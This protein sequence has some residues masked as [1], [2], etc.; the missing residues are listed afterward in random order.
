LGYPQG[1]YTIRPLLLVGDETHTGGY[2]EV[3]LTS[4]DDL[5]QDLAVDMADFILAIKILVSENIDTATP[6]STDTD[7]KIGMDN[8][9]R[10]LREIAEDI[11]PSP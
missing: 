1:R 8:V 11:L 9:L 5:N 3:L 2:A 6:G 7:G 10:I 4:P